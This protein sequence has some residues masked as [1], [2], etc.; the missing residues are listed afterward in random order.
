MKIAIVRTL[1]LGEV[2][3]HRKQRNAGELKPQL[4]ADARGGGKLVNA[5]AQGR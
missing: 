1:A 5:K 4:N 3:N 2:F